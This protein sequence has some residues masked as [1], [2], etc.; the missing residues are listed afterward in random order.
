[1]AN[2]IN[3]TVSDP[4]IELGSNNLGTNDLGIIMT[5]PNNNSNVAVVFDESVDILRMGY[6][7]NGA[8]DSIIDLDS[9]ALAVSVQGELTVGSNL[10]VGTANLFVDTTTGKVSIGAATPQYKLDVDGGTTEGDGDVMLRLMGGGNMAGK[11][12]F[13]R[14]GTADLRSHA[15]ECKNNVNTAAG[16]FMKFL[17]H[18]GGNT[19]PH[20]TR[21][22]VMTLQGDGNVGIGETSPAQKLDVDGRIRANS[23][24][25]DDYIHHV[26]DMGTYMGFGG[27]DNITMVT[28]S[29]ERLRLDGGGVQGQAFVKLGDSN[30]EMWFPASDTIAWNTGGT[31]RM[32]IDSSGRVGIGTTN[33]TSI[34]PTRKFELGMNYGHLSG[35]LDTYLQMGVVA[36]MVMGVTEYNGTQ[37]DTL[38]ISDSG[39]VGIGTT[40]PTRKFELGM[41]TGHLAG[42]IDTYVQSGVVAGMILGVKQSWGPELDTLYIND[43]GRVGIGTNNPFGKLHVEHYGSAIGDFLG[44]RIANHATNYH[45]TSRPAYDFVVSDIS[46]GTGIGASKF[47]IGYRGTTSASRTDRLVIDSSGYVGIGTTNPLAPLDI[48]N[49]QSG[50]ISV[51]SYQGGYYWTWN[52]PAQKYYNSPTD[53]VAINADGGWLVAWGLYAGYSIQFLSDRR[54]KK[55]IREIDDDSALEKFRLLKPSKY[56]Y[57]EPAISGRTDKEVYGFI[58][59]EVA[60]VL[61]EGVSIGGSDRDGTNQGHIPNL[62]LIH[63]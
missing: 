57:I 2:T 55:D 59:Q 13:G 26:G 60:E 27:I 42:Y 18:D 37:V 9:N 40:N 43:S 48:P 63:I 8:S 12:I 50:T 45:S 41:N 3:M 5:R 54:I 33:Q 14:T 61:P 44:L 17:V 58:A 1:M 34:N 24:E 4:I 53:S 10:E 15:I 51:N 28:G 21:T 16:N 36:G 29:T 22:T 38:Y 20:E 25:M 7:L 46:S 19:P 11:L 6:T 30:T 23:M 47:A 52:T 39:Y 49:N 31:E 56:K 32:R 35:Y 62:S